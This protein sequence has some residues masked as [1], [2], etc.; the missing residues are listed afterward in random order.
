M[1]NV[2]SVREID[3]ESS[4]D[5]GLRSSQDDGTGP[6]EKRRISNLCPR[7]KWRPKLVD[8]IALKKGVFSVMFCTKEKHGWW[9]DWTRNEEWKKKK[10]KPCH[11]SR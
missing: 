8:T 5:G 10:K 11:N 2:H 4:C 3:R 1:I 6:K 7:I 9:K